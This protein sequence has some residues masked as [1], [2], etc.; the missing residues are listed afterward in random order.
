MWRWMTTNGGNDMTTNGGNDMTTN[1][2]QAD[3]QDGSILDR[4]H[5]EFI[6]NHKGKTSKKRI[7]ELVK[8]YLSATAARTK[9]EAAVEA[10]VRAESDAATALIREACGKQKVSIAGTL[11]SPMSRGER[12]FFRRESA[13]AIELG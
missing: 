1:G 13:E 2:T 11:Y 7:E 4:L 5:A 3:K 8:A 9:A 12:V 10:A 6:R